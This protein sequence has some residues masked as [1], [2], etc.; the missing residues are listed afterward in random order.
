MP[1][2][3]LTNLAGCLG[4]SAGGQASSTGTASGWDA[5]CQSFAKAA[6][7]LL[8]SFARSFSSIPPIDLSY[9]GIRSVYGL[10][11]EIAAVVAAVLLMVQV[12]RTAMTHDG[13]AIVQ[14]LTGIGKAALA[15]VLIL[16]AAATALRASDE[17]TGWII[18]RTFGT[19]Q[20]LAG[21]LG[22]LAAF[23]GVSPS[24]L[25]VLAL[26]GILLTLALWAQLL[27]RNIAVTVLV[28]VSPIAAAGQ[29]AH[30]SQQWWRKLVRVTIQLIALKP[31]VALIFA[32]G[33]T[34]P[35]TSGGVEKLLTG[36]LVLLLAGIAWPAMARASAVFEVYLAG[37]SLAGI[38]GGERVHGGSPAGVNPA[39]LSR[40]AEARTM[41][42][43]HEAHA[44][45]AGARE[46]APARPRPGLALDA[47]SR[48]AGPQ[49]ARPQAL[50]PG[51]ATPSP[52]QGGDRPAEL[53]AGDIPEPAATN[54]AATTGAAT[55]GAATTGA[56][57]TG[58]A[59]TVPAIT[60]APASWRNP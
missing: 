26:A 53:P 7:Q 22:Q 12:I 52:G 56:A 47:S 48:T 5:I 16:G 25:L 44:R 14:G 10:S 49:A 45:P 24:L 35:G 8:T 3:P 23:R 2:N 58:A 51:A 37:G 1:C 4:S 9:S 28:A 31:A 15:F 30:A 11:L 55:A 27:V 39:E 60:G 46:Q 54:D 19:P 38:R 57:T 6:Q 43:V 40:V 21:R 42:A 41:T 36:L 20:A 13:S 59:T 17:L 18:T 29:V 34:L 50:G 33:L 32:V